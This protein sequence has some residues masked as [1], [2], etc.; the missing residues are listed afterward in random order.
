MRRTAAGQ[1]NESTRTGENLPVG[2]IGLLNLAAAGTKLSVLTE[3][4]LVG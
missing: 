4:W 3:A 2:F 1:A